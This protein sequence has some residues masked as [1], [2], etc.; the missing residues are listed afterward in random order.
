M[1][2]QDF[3]LVVFCAI[4]DELKALLGPARL[5]ARGPEPTLSDAE[6][7]AIELVGEFLGL[8]DDAALYRHFRRYHAAEFPGLLRIGRTTFVR[9]AAN[10]C[11]VKRRL[12]ARFAARLAR[13]GPVWLVDSLPPPVCRFARAHGSRRF[14]G[15]VGWGYD[16]TARKAFYGSRL[17]LRTS[18][19]G[20]ILGYQPAPAD[21][22]ETEVI[23][24]LAPTPPGT[25][26]GDRNY[27]SPSARAAFEGAAGRPVAPY[28]LARYDR[29]R[30]RSAALLALR[31]RIEDAN[32]QLVG[33]YDCRRIKVR[34]VGHLEHRLVR[35]ILSL[36][37]AMGLNAR[38]GHEPLQLEKLVA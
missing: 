11:W 28:K 16:A 35:K 27:W 21:A 22:A 31:R 14:A 10:T 24:E 34:D 37:V 36:T 12:Q 2:P 18:V 20:V 33:R 26:L 3:L 1:T 7:I 17:H 30:P 25:A 8:A 32:G 23:R 29:D 13:P 19:A 4:D 6:V 38:L 15:R 5:R 9:Q